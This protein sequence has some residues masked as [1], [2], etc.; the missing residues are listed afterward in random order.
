MSRLRGTTPNQGPD[1]A[2]RLARMPGAESTTREVYMTRLCRVLRLRA[3]WRD[4]LN[5]EGLRLLRRVEAETLAMC[6][7]LGCGTEARRIVETVQ[8]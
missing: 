4:Q 1:A 7:E 3:E 5:D 8:R 2:R 6:D